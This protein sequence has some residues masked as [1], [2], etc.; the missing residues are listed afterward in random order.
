MKRDLALWTGVLTGPVV[1]AL[2]FVAKFTISYWICAFG[3]KPAA[4]ALSIVPLL[5][6]AYAGWLSWSIWREL[7]TEMPGQTGG[8]IGRSRALALAGVALS[9]GF[10]IV[11][12]AQTFP[13]L[14]LAG[15]E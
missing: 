1:W 11:L 14:I 7:G 8:V 3:W 9:I 5:P 15:C 6:T 10:G 13:E 2:F 12:I 4:Y